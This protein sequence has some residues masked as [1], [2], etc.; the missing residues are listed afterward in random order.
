[1]ISRSKALQY[2]K[3]RFGEDI[4]IEFI[5]RSTGQPRIMTFRQGVKTHLKGGKAAYDF[6]DQ[7]LLPV[8]DIHKDKYRCIPKENITRIWISGAWVDVARQSA[9]VTA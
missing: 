1:M 6:S 9:L 5:K 4:T 8:F 2:I 3:E 7:G